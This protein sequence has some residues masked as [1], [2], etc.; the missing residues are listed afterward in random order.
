MEYK[1]PQTEDSPSKPTRFLVFKE[2]IET[3]LNPE[4]KDVFLFGVKKFVADPYYQYDLLFHAKAGILDPYCR[5]RPRRMIIPVLRGPNS[6]STICGM[7]S[8]HPDFTRYGIARERHVD[9]C[10]TLSTSHGMQLQ[11]LG[12]YKGIAEHV[13]W[14]F[15]RR[16]E[17]KRHVEFLRSAIDRRFR[18]KRC[19]SATTK[20]IAP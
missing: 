14:D 20:T 8:Q 15:I 9:F 18:P 13:F 16:P 11:P 2:L 1:A 10:D 12:K 5:I 4:L 7:H 19:I 6:F 17:L 3:A